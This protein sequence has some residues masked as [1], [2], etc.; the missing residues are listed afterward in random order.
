MIARFTY[1]A[2]LHAAL[3]HQLASIHASKL[4]ASLDMPFPAG[5]KSLT[6]LWIYELRWN[7]FS[8]QTL[9]TR[10]MLLLLEAGKCACFSFSM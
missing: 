6:A 8:L 3:L 1:I 7:T 5:V 4:K 2:S 9:G 10:C